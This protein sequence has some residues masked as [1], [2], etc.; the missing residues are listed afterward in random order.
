MNQRDSS[1]PLE[2]LMSRAFRQRKIEAKKIAR[3]IIGGELLWN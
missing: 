1:D 3:P 2:S